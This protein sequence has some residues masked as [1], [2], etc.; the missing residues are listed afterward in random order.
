M[1]EEGKSMGRKISIVYIMQ[2]LQHESDRDHPLSQQ[3]II[4][5]LKDQYNLSMERK[6]VRRNLEFLKEAG[7]PVV[8]READ[9]MIQ[10]HAA[11][12]S[13]DWYWDHSF[14]KDDL[15][16]L[17]DLLYF[18]HLPTAQVKQLSEKLRGLYSRYFKDGKDMVKN[19]PNSQKMNYPDDIVDILSS[20]ISEKKQVTFFYDH[21]EADGKRHHNR[22][23]GNKEIRYVVNPYVVAASDQRYFFLGNKEGEENITT[24]SVELMADVEKTDIEARPPKSVRDVESVIRTSD[25]FMPFNRTYTGRAEECIFK[26]NWHLMTDIVTDF[27]K[28]AYLL[29]ATQGWVDVKVTAPLAAVRAWALKNAPYVKVVS[30]ITLVQSVRDA[31]MNLTKLYGDK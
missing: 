12:L 7:F 18:S 8:C 10:G 1:A 22:G 31:A 19:I 17:V 23:F 14:D 29:S 26:A 2:I 13:L 30:P 28:D 9:R 4:E 11:H 24:F 25:Y 16:T 21:Y 5:I 27:G 15:Q 3:N 6:S 20:A